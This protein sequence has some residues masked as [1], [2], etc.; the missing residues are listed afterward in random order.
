MRRLAI[1]DVSSY[2]YC[3]YVRVCVCVFCIHETTERRDEPLKMACRAGGTFERDKWWQL[4]S[5]LSASTA[6]RSST[7]CSVRSRSTTARCD[8]VRWWWG[9]NERTTVVLQMLNNEFIIHITTDYVTKFRDN[10]QNGS[11]VYV[12]ALGLINRTPMIICCYFT[13]TV[14]ARNS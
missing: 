4:Y 9:T 14:Y 8:I 6:S 2:T 10:G 13:K 5:C 3:T 11:T 7:P 1:P 12:S